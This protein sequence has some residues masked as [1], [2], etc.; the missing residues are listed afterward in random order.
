MK[1]TVIFILCCIYFFQNVSAQVQIQHEKRIFTDDKGLVY[2][3]IELPVYFKVS[4]S[5][6]VN[7]EKILLESASSPQYTNPM[8]FAK[9]GLNTVYSPSAVDTTTLIPIYP[10][11]NVYFQIYVDGTAPVTTIHNNSTPYIKS[12]TLYFG[13]DVKIKFDTK[14]KI[15]GIEKTYYSI[16]GSEYKEYSG[17][18]LTF[19]KEKEYLLKFYSVDN[20]GNVE[21][22]NEVKFTIDGS[23]P[24]TNLKVTGDYIDKVISGT[25]TISL[26]PE[27]AFAGVSTT[28]YILDNNE[29]QVYSTP[30]SAKLLAEG[31]H[32]L[33]YYT[34]DNVF[35]DEENKIYNFFVDKTAPI[36]IDE[37]Q[38]DSFFANGKEYSSG[39]SKLKLTAIDNRA[40]VKEIYYSISGGEWIL[41]DKP[42]YLPSQNGSIEIDFYAID[43]VNNKNASDANN[44]ISK[45][46]FNSFIDLLGPELSYSYDGK[47]FEFNDTT[48]I[49]KNT[50]IILKGYDTDAGM[51][52]ITYNL[53]NNSDMEYNEAL[54]ISGDGSHTIDFFGYD[55]VNNSNLKS[56]YFKVDEKGP[57]IIPQFSLNSSGKKNIDG[58][59]YTI[60]PSHL[61]LYL[62]A[63]DSMVGVEKIYYS[64]NGQTEKLYSAFFSIFQKGSSYSLKTRA[65]DYLG[66]ET[67]K[68]INFYIAN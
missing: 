10:K 41:Y 62:S 7:S 25:S 44:K 43:N 46:S 29:K 45:L 67:T 20:V 3:N 21:K 14:E 55:N 13:L 63:F 18:A 39:R 11:Q 42:F 6:N 30:I 54:N 19:D 36:I 58:I 66:N 35:N 49:S 68:E 32:T 16:D 17:D 33:T 34:T 48:Y 52:N 56:F 15:S 37:I 24:M 47:S 1:K 38:G 60:Y 26:K 57:E 27:D 51:K 9:E 5:R 61:I 65:I 23:K 2:I 64:L 28:Y 53:D 12:D 4:A 8:Y 31:E 50:K 59:E 22:V 40:G